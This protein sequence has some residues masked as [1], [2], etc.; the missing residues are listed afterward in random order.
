M[1]VDLYVNLCVCQCPRRPEALRSSG[2]EVKGSC[3]LPDMGSRT[4]IKVLCK[5][6]YT[7]LTNEPFL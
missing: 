4:W 1:C 2:A 5:G 7:L 3:E 6:N